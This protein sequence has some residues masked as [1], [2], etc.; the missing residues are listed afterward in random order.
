MKLH[1]LRILVAVQEGGSLQ[2]ASKR[3][4]ITQP[5]LS[6]ALKELEDELGVP[7]LIRSSKG[8]T[9]TPYGESLMKHARGA[10]ESVRRAQQD[11]NDMKGET[12]LAV[13]L[14]VTSAATTLE[15]VTDTVADFHLKYPK[16]KLT[17]LEQ[18]PLQIQELLQQGA[19]D[20]AITSQ[21]PS[22]S[23]SMEWLPVCR[24]GMDVWIRE[25]HPL[26][27]VRSLRQLT[28]VTWLTQDSAENPHST[29]RR[30][31][32]QNGLAL[33]QYLIECNSSLMVRNLILKADA[34]FMVIRSF[35]HAVE[36][37]YLNGMRILRLEEKIPDSIIGIVCQDQRLLT[38]TA[39]NLLG[40]MRTGLLASY[41]RFE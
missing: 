38:R 36:P 20:F 13:R 24:L 26:G 19:L 32:E 39:A 9:P 15:P 12:A 37:D 3:L 21:I 34:L 18:R 1:Q 14:G 10:L 28:D 30:L 35:M 33:P 2:E 25:G 11:I 7:L 29:I 6:R 4:H 22:Q 16:V 8:V 23:A 17:V 27:T 40:L 31:F 41:P 5:A